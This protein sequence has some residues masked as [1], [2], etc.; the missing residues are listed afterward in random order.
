[1]ITHTG[2]HEK[3]R[4]N[5]PRGDRKRRPAVHKYRVKVQGQP[6]RPTKSRIVY[7]RLPPLQSYRLATGL[8]LLWPIAPGDQLKCEKKKKGEAI[9]SQGHVV[10]SRELRRYHAYVVPVQ[11]SLREFCGLAALRCYLT[12]ASEGY[13]EMTN[14]KGE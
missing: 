4:P 12:G 7:G 13:V 8:C 1:M 9:V 10:L 6:G 2:G 3:L 5:Y 11:K 14:E